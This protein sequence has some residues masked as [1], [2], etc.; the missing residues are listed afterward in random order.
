M[1]ESGFVVS[2]ELCQM[3]QIRIVGIVAGVR[4][5]R[6]GLCAGDTVFSENVRYTVRSVIAIDRERSR[7]GDIDSLFVFA[8][9][10]VVDAQSGVCGTGEDVVNI[11]VDTHVSAA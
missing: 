8:L 4:S 5:E 2:A 6:I 7:G 3:T 1:I 10:H 9:I 11:V